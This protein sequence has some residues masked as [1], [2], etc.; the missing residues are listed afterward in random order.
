[1]NVAVA[2]EHRR[3]GHRARRCSQ[4]LFELT[5]GDDRRGYT[6]EVRVSNDGAI[7][8]YERLGF[9]GARR[10]ARLL[11]RQPRGRADHVEGPGRGLRPA[12]G[13]S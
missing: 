9:V 8:L 10:P 11:H 7:R 3:R 4:Q 2:P 1:M 5:A 13:A 12:A 6:L